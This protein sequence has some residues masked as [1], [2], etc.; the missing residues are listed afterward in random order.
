MPVTVGLNIEREE[1]DV[2]AGI[3]KMNGKPIGATLTDC[4]RKEAAALAGSAKGKIDSSDA[5]D[6]RTDVQTPVRPYGRTDK[7]K[8]SSG[9][10]GG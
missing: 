5:D 1:Y 8:R 7:S 4:L 3:L 6:V 9:K 2:L 10:D